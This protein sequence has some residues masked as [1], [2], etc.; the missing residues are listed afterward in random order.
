[1]AV[2]VTEPSAPAI[3]PNW[4]ARAA[5][6]ALRALKGGGEQAA[7]DYLA[8]HPGQE[9]VTLAL[10]SEPWSSI[11]RMAEELSSVVTDLCEN[12]DP[13]DTLADLRIQAGMVKAL[14]SKLEDRTMNIEL[15]SYELVDQLEGEIEEFEYYEDEGR[16]E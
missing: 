13:A 2:G 11:M 8:A 3:V 9:A 1:M 10:A 14:A 4:P 5:G 12:T 7:S 16:S 6:V 15:A